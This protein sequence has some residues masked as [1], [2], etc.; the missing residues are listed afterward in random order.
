M[1]LLYCFMVFIFCVNIEIFL[2]IVDV[3]VLD[4]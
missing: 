4:N 1:L 3:L 2:C